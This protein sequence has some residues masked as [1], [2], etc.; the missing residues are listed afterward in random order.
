MADIM[1][2][3]EKTVEKR[4]MYVEFHKESMNTI[5]RL[6]NV[7]SP[8]GLFVAKNE[9]ENFQTADDLKTYIKNAKKSYLAQGFE[10]AAAPKKKEAE[11][12]ELT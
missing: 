10:D 5:K 4:L 1:L 8:T 7:V 11:P 6:W 2:R 12:I 3:L 9:R